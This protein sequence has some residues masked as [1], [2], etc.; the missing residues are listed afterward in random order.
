M[1]FQPITHVDG[2]QYDMMIPDKVEVES[3][4][5]IEVSFTD[6]DGTVFMASL[7]TSR[8]VNLVKDLTQ[9]LADQTPH[10]VHLDPNA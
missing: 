2:R 10:K 8:A 6:N 5:L 7:F 3:G 1:A 9:A 4:P